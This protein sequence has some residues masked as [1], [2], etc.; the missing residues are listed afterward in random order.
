MIDPAPALN[1]ARFLSETPNRIWLQIQAPQ[2]LSQVA[3]IAVTGLLAFWL[4]QAV[5]LPLARSLQQ[6]L[7][8]SWALGAHRVAQHVAQPVGWIAL[9]WGSTL[10]A[11]SVG[12]PVPLIDAAVDLV[13]AWICIRVLSFAVSS[14]TV[15]AVISVAAWS[16][17]ALN[18]LGLLKPL[19]RYLQSQV[20]YESKLHRVSVLDCIDAIIVLIALLW[21]TRLVSQFL[22]HRIAK[23]RS[24][25]PS[26]QVLLRQLAQIV[27]P[28]VAIII[29]LQTVGVDLTT[30]TV[31]FGAIGLGVGLGLQKLVSNLVAG[32]ALLLGKSIKPGDVVEYKN[33]YGWVTEMGAR[34]V[35]LRTRDGIEHLVPNDYFLENGVENWSHSDLAL[36]LHVPVGISY[37]SD[38]H[39]ALAVCKEAAKSVRRVLAQPDPIVLVKEFGDSSIN[40]EIRF[41]IDDPR[42]GTSNVKSEVMVQI[43]DRFAASGIQIPYP[44]RDVH[45]ISMPSDFTAGPKENSPRSGQ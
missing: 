14:S 15:S 37:N 21:L 32:L 10:L 40:L 36:R 34:Y 44:Q 24:L 38:L 13:F 19:M 43:W 41:W 16:V 20:I 42:N 5:R 26:L 1:L 29:A 2:F 33:S 7:P 17:A 25:T 35:T 23:S 11:S 45:I 18:I 22:M 39:Q 3:V 12:V 8:T 28:A 4:A 9:L 31:A 6:N 30:L 27:L